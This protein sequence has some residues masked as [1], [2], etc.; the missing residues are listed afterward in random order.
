MEAAAKRWLSLY[1]KEIAP[2]NDY[3]DRPLFDFLR[4]ASERLPSKVAIHFL[5]K[6][7]TFK[8]LYDDTV[9]LASALKRLGLEKGDRA[10]IMLPNCPQSVISYFAILMVGGVAVQ[11]NPL[12]T[13]HELEHQLKDSGAKMIVCLDALL[14]R[15]QKAG[16]K[17]DLETIIVTGVQDFLP[18]PKNILYPIASKV[19]IPKKREIKDLENVYVLTDL[20]QS[21]TLNFTPP[22]ISTDEDLALLQ[23]TGGTTGIAK[24]VMLTH[25]NLIANTSQS[26]MWMYR[27]EYGKE[28]VLGVLPFFHVYGMTIVMNLAIMYG[29]K[30]V[31]LPRFNVEETLKTIEKQRPT[32]FPGAP[33]MYIALINH[34]EI[35]KYDV[36]SIETCISG[37][38]PLPVE[39][40]QTFERLTG[41]KLVEGYGLSESSPV[42]HCNLIWGERVSGSIGIPYPDTEAKI[43]S[44]DGEECAVNEVGELV[45]KGPQVMKGY[46]RRPDETDKVLKDGWLFTGDM[47]YMDEKGYFYIVDR[48]KDVIIASG[49]NIYP[50]EVEEVL[51]EHPDVQEA[52]VIGVQD[53]Y[54]GETVKAF[55]VPKQGRKLDEK[56]LD[57]HCRK[58]LAP[59]KVP[60]KYEFRAELPKTIIGKVLKR[61]LIEEE[62]R[63][64]KSS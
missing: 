3:Q 16:L 2:T 1:P 27:H 7:I 48:K 11:T 53:D 41:G 19:R 47:A 26:C 59:Y 56:T 58:M 49:Y 22:D 8:R 54:R 6:E 57:A 13:E 40:Q 12:Y 64:R 25:R 5:G 10:A 18:F 36:S 15:V 52:A 42:T 32:L 9:K 50:R 4:E 17:T 46:W 35:T 45:V 30:M 29:A 23:Y 62:K 21:G 37:S 24:G 33:T 38:A 44:E 28:V 43:I 55:I 60:K 34:P 61:E 14:P 51:Y 20:I 31:I 39:V 63:K